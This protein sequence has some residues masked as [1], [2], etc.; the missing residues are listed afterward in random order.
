MAIVYYNSEK[1]EIKDYLAKQKL[2]EIRK[3]LSE[4]GNEGIYLFND[5]YRLIYDLVCY[6]A[7]YINRLY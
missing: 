4:Y 6:K 5:N 1:L 7:R 2:D 3:K